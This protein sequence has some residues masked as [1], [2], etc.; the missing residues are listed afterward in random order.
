[1]VN[2]FHLETISFQAIVLLHHMLIAN[3]IPHN[4][5]LATFVDTADGMLSAHELPTML[6]MFRLYA[7]SLCQL[8][9]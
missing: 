7:S 4:P 3:E 9:Q 2:I 8:V 5:N 1:L 6:P